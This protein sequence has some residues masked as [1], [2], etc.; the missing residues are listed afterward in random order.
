MSA[1][2]E[3]AAMSAEQLADLAALEQSASGAPIVPGSPEAIAAEAEANRP[4][5]AQE[6]AGMANAFIA[7]TGPMFPSLRTIYTEETTSAAAQSLAALCNKHGWLQGGVMGEYSEEITALIVCGPLAIATYSGIQA[8][9]AARKPAVKKVSHQ[10]TAQPAQSIADDGTVN[11]KTVII[12]API[13]M[14]VASDANQ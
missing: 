8:D 11:Q 5:L 12:G 9:I 13:P 1:A 7:I 4:D 3:A 14:E 10:A 6:I 2:K